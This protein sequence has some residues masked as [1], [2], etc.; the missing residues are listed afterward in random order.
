MNWQKA[1][2]VDEF[3]ELCFRTVDEK[4]IQITTGI[5]IQVQQLAIKKVALTRRL[6]FFKI[7]FM[8]DALEG[9][10]RKRS[11]GFFGVVGR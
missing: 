1:A 5:Q 11:T 9:G 2:K 4:K 3:N 6:D 7:C 8:S 10:R